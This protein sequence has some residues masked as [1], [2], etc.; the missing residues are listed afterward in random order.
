LTA[1]ARKMQQDKHGRKTVLTLEGAPVSID[2][3][4]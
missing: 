4:R 3:M 2:M 1:A